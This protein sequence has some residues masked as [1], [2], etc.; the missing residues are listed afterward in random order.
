MGTPDPGLLG[1]AERNFVEAWSTFG[2]LPGATF[3]EAAGFARLVTG[4][5]H[6]LANA[7]L[8]SEFEADAADRV[9][10]TVDAFDLAG[11]PFTW[12]LTPGARPPTLGSF[13]SA[14]GLVAQPDEPM[15]ALR[16]ADLDPGDR[17][18]PSG[19]F[20]V[21]RVRTSAELRAFVGLMGETLGFPAVLCDSFVVVIE[22]AGLGDDAGW[23]HYAGVA[24]GEIVAI[25]SLFRGSA[26]GGIYNVGC[27]EAF[28]GRGFGSALTAA[29][30]D[31]GRRLGYQAATLQS[32]EIGLGVYGRLGFRE[33][34][35]IGAFVRPSGEPAQP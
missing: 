3:E 20:A 18:A 33:V 29:A 16:Y 4:L 27:R 22:A 7:V 12:W 15:M 5:P 24:D 23:R 28:R 25:S 2:T 30:L 31:D 19:R 17:E 26:L 11:V 13:L 32:S 21:R 35:R 14:R 9:R 8:R 34:G 10:A 1:A 6:P